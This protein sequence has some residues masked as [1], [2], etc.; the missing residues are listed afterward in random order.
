MNAN[1]SGEGTGGERTVGFDE[2][3]QLTFAQAEG[4]EPLPR[5]LRPKELPKSLRAGLWLAIYESLEQHTDRSEFMSPWGDIFRVMHVARDHE[6]I[7]DFVNDVQS[8][9]HKTRAVFETGN[10]VAVFDWIQW[11]L[12]CGLAPS[13]LAKDIDFVLTAE[14]AAYRI[15]DGDTIVPIGSEAELVTI[16]QAFADLAAAE[17]RGARAH[18]RKAS[19][20]LTAGRYADS[21]RESIHSVESVAKILEPTADLSKALAKLERSASI[22]G[23][24]K[25]AF[26]KLYGYTSDE[27]GIRHALL[28][29]G[30]AKV[31]ETDALFMIGACAAFVSY[32]INKARAAGILSG[33]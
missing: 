22:H 26:I 6:M 20:E 31:D 18:L 17:F 11:V 14:R 16:E 23:G 9:V 27:K 15:V 32:L 28:D 19:E 25:G 5:Q 7:D 3:K 10:Y 33:A 4:A 24:M 8:L 1:R 12:R 13:H 21:V 2:R 30:T 29:D